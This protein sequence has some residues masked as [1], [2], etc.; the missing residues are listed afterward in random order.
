MTKQM[1]PQV[2]GSSSILV[3][4]IV[5]LVTTFGPFQV[6]TPA[7]AEYEYYRET[8]S[9]VDYGISRDITLRNPHQ[10][11]WITDLTY[12]L[13]LPADGTTLSGDGEWFQDAS[14]INASL[15]EIES[16]E[17]TNSHIRGQNN[18]SGYLIVPAETADF[19]AEA[20][21]TMEIEYRA[22]VNVLFWTGDIAPDGEVYLEVLYQVTTRA[23]QWEDEDGSEI[24]GQEI[25]AANSGNV[26][27][28]EATAA[29]ASPPYDFDEILGR[30][31]DRGGGN[32]AIDPEDPDI[33]SLAETVAG[34]I[35]NV[36]EQVEA[37]FDWMAEN[38]NS[39]DGTVEIRTA[40]QVLEDRVGDCDEQSFLFISMARS[41]GIP[42]YIEVGLMTDSVRNIWIGH[43]WAKVVMPVRGPGEKIG[44]VVGSIDMVNKI[45]LIHHP[46]YL[47][48][49]IDHEDPSGQDLE[50]IYLRITF[51]G[52]IG[53]TLIWI[54]DTTTVSRTNGPKVRFGFEG[55]LPELTLADLAFLAFWCCVLPLT[56]L[57]VVGLGVYFVFFKDKRQE[58]AGYPY[59]MLYPGQ[60]GGLYDPY[61]PTQPQG[62]VQ[63]D[64]VQ[65]PPPPGPFV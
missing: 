33:F 23:Y 29:G 14:L 18:G 22:A 58:Q 20:S 26:S 2:H 49:F 59:S 10:S 53:S 17:V 4:A 9:W 44:L 3:V 54:E 45:F 65:N 38:I 8:Y 11:Q 7:E 63:P 56:T 27:D 43:A 42:S 19:T 16:I 25:A 21:A 60:P 41:L 15:Q 36:F 1:K 51:T 64:Q 24:T 32:W 57:I 39:S 50:E 37:I 62:M 52:P 12:R 28:I 55:E 34:D 47:S 40:A 13:P 61:Q 6:A 48:E 5:V 46:S 30:S 31:W 35:D